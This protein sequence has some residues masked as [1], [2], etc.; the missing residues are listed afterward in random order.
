MDFTTNLVES[1]WQVL[2]Y[3]VLKRR[4]NLCPIK[5][6]RHLVGFDD[7]LGDT[8]LGH[9][10][11]KER[12]AAAGVGSRKNIVLQRAARQHLGR[13]LYSKH[14]GCLEVDKPGV[15]SMLSREEL[16]FS[17]CSSSHEHLK[18]TCSLRIHRGADMV[19]LCDCP[20]GTCG[21]CK[22]VIACAHF[23]NDKFGHEIV[24]HLQTLAG[25][26][27]VM[28]P[29]ANLKRSTARQSKPKTTQQSNVMAHD[30]EVQR[31]VKV[32]D[33]WLARIAHEDPLAGTSFADIVSKVLCS[34]PAIDETA[35]ACSDITEYAARTQATGHFATS[36]RREGATGALPANC[37]RLDH[38][39]ARRSA[40]IS[41][42]PVATE[43]TRSVATADQE[44][45]LMQ[46][47]DVDISGV[48][49]GTCPDFGQPQLPAN[50]LQRATAPVRNRSVSKSM[51][52]TGGKRASAEEHALY[53]P[54]SLLTASLNDGAQCQEGHRHTNIYGVCLATSTESSDMQTYGTVYWAGRNGEE[55]RLT[56]FDR[57]RLKAKKRTLKGGIQQI[58]RCK[59]APSIFRSIAD[60]ID[61]HSCSLAVL[62]EQMQL[63]WAKQVVRCNFD[64]CDSFVI[65]LPQQGTKRPRAALH[66]QLPDLSK[67]FR[68]D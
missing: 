7:T 38:R 35:E 56:E 40:A 17:V 44:R 33:G 46:L 3:K 14:K 10:F 52:R 5:L 68:Y 23:A 30:T 66:S 42:A 37:L 34:G 49:T 31:A 64:K 53:G 58:S 20:T 8:L 36:L 13:E 2:K 28:K 29:S 60:L 43:P 47:H 48:H 25:F 19:A 15:I 59:H 45:L 67:L 39:S 41:T 55:L 62:P 57:V 21:T 54:G 51:V 9:I 61:Q 18:Y 11:H 6:F 16:V 63:A 12:A 27:T 24:S 1:H 50:P 32:L 4:V 26:G 65:R 22:H